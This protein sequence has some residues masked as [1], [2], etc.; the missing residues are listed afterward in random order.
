MDI[1]L[2]RILSLIPHKPDGKFV[3]GAKKVF[4]DKIGINTTIL[5]Q[6]LSEYSKSYEQY[7]YQIA[8]A[9]NVS[10]E[11]LKGETDD[12]APKQKQDAGN[13]DI[14]QLLRDSIPLMSNKDLAEAM[15]LLVESLGNKE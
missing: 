13:T 11:W 3:H 9:Y 1:M 10:V 7:V 5:S 4:C 12:P 6:W 14:L 2:E 8:D 15:R